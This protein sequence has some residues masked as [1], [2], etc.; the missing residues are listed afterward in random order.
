LFSATRQ[1]CSPYATHC[2][3][4]LGL[5]TAQGQSLAAARVRSPRSAFFR[6]S[7]QGHS[8]FSDQKEKGI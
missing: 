2:S 1:Q 4:K 8:V 3:E 5:N 6:M 7:K